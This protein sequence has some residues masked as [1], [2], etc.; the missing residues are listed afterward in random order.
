L[1]RVGLR[2]MKSSADMIGAIL[3]VRRKDPKG[4]IVTCEAETGP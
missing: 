4:T 1:N 3:D 2:I